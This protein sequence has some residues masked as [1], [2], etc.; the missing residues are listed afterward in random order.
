MFIIAEKQGEGEQIKLTGKAQLM[1]KVKGHKTFLC[2]F[3]KETIS[4]TE[5]PHSL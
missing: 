2:V 1:K 5:F 4:N 3:H